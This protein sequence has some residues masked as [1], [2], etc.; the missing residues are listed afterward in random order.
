MAIGYLW[1]A[2][3]NVQQ[4][5]KNEKWL[6]KP[7]YEAFIANTKPEEFEKN[8]KDVI[9]AYTYVGVYFMNNKEICKAKPYFSKIAELDASNTNAKKFLE[10]AEAKKCE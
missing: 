3:A 5:L 2:R 9:E 1:R 8:K 10:S 6:A 7:Y 4:D